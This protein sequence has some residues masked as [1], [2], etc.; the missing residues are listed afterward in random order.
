M[1]TLQPGDGP[2]RFDKDDPFA[3]ALAENGYRPTDWCALFAGRG[4]WL[5]RGDVDDAPAVVPAARVEHVGALSVTD[6]SLSALDPFLP[7]SLRSVGTLAHA[8]SNGEHPVFAA[9]GERGELYAIWVDLTG[10]AGVRRWIP[11]H[12][13]GAELPPPGAHT[14]LPG[15]HATLLTSSPSREWAPKGM[16]DALNDAGLYA[17][18]GVVVVKTP[19]GPPHAAVGFDAADA[20]AALVVDVHRLRTPRQ[21]V[22]DIDLGETPS[23][24]LREH[25]FLSLD[26]MVSVSVPDPRTSALDAVVAIDSGSEIPP[27][28]SD[29]TVG[30]GGARNLQLVFDPHRGA[31]PRRFRVRW[32][33]PSHPPVLLDEA[34]VRRALVDLGVM[35]FIAEHEARALVADAAAPGWEPSPL[36]AELLL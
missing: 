3:L 7:P 31:A 5:R 17:K 25:G 10:A 15:R 20:P 27:R 28:R 11:A 12:L 26:T 14:A 2:V 24:F 19:A 6:G 33:A 4:P 29:W 1:P 18:D 32:R 34:H 8:L 21:E 16:Q 13:D 36:V 9:R 23:L 35:P 22:D 30:A